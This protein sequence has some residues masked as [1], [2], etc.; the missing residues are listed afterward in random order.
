MSE[1]EKPWMPVVAGILDIVSG[2]MGMA[3]G[4]FMSLYMPVA[5]AAQA[6][7]GDVPRVTPHF[8]ALPQMPFSLFPDMGLAI[9]ITIAVFGALS[10][11]YLH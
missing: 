11:E 3:M 1:M 10:A 8:G 2:A 4:L 7:A 5:K 6:S 9:G